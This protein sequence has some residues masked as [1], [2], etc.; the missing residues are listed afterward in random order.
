MGAAGAYLS[1]RF[2]FIL[3]GW[4][5]AKGVTKRFAISYEGTTTVNWDGEPLMLIGCQ[6]IHALYALVKRRNVLIQD[7][8][9]AIGSIN[10]QPE[11]LFVAEISKIIEWINRSGLHGSGGRCNTKR[12]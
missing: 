4:N 5:Q 3:T 10:V 6:G 2:V 9:S 12:P 11:P 7:A 1:S 8:E